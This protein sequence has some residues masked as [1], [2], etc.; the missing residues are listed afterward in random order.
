MTPKTKTH[1]GSNTDKIAAFSDLIY[2]KL[3]SSSKMGAV[4][5][6][7]LIPNKLSQMG[8][9]EGMV[10]LLFISDKSKQEATDYENQ[11]AE[12]YE[13]I[14]RLKVENDFLKK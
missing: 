14:G 4:V 7:M 6:N 8:N 3:Y 2:S 12:L 10:R 5:D 1:T 13:Q 11:L 9:V